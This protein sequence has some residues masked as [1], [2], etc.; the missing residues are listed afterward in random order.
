LVK[1]PQNLATVRAGFDLPMPPSLLVLAVEVQRAL[2]SRGRRSLIPGKVV[3]ALVQCW[4]AIEGFEGFELKRFLDG[5]TD[6]DAPA[7]GKQV[8]I[9]TPI[10]E[11]TA[12]C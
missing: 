6:Q 5:Q 7:G 3:A 4:R 9:G 10:T 12:S 11:P 1:N 8:K 2:L